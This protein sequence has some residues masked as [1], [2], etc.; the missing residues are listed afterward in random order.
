VRMHLANQ[1]DSLRAMAA[2]FGCAAAPVTVVKG[3]AVAGVT[4]QVIA[5]AS[6]KGGVGKTTL[7]ANL[8]IAFV[9]QHAR[10]LALD[11]DLGLANLDLA[12]GIRPQH[13]FLDLIEGSVGIEEILAAGPEGIAVLPACSGQYALANLSDCDRQGLFGAVDMLEAGYDTLLIDTAAGIGSNAV[14][15]AGAAQQVVVVACNEPTSLADA[16]AFVKV[17]WSRCRNS[18]VHLVANMVSS[19]AEGEE[20][21]RRLCGLADRF[22]G[23]GIDYLGPVTRDPAVV[24]SIHAGVPV[25]VSEPGAPASRCIENI[26]RRLVSF[27]AVDSPAGGIGLFW[28]RLLSREARA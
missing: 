14:A 6:G 10:V 19:A 17:L 8:A 22:L 12:L 7:V 24:R 20:V 1:A 11:G 25:L 21:Y 3:K 5:V 13:T 23:V 28:K 15:F 2:P 18:K 27:A 26:A 16:Y 9:R 4:P